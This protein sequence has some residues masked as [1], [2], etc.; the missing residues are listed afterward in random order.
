MAEVNVGNF[1]SSLFG[2]TPATNRR[3]TQA[4]TAATQTATAQRQQLIDARNAIADLMGTPAAADPAGFAQ[5]QQPGLERGAQAIRGQQAE[6]AARQAETTAQREQRLAAQQQAERGRQRMLNA[7]RLAND[8]VQAAANAGATPEEIGRVFDSSIRVA[9]GVDPSITD[10]QVAFLRE[11]VQQNPAALESII[12]AFDPPPATAARG[13]EALGAPQQVQVPGTDQVGLAVPVDMGGGRIQSVFMRDAQGEIL[14]A[15]R[16]ERGLAGEGEVTFRDE[17]GNLQALQ[18][19]GTAAE[20]ETEQTRVRTEQTREELREA[21][22][23]RVA[24]AQAAMRR[25][26]TEEQRFDLVDERIDQ[27]IDQASGL[28]AGL[29]S[30]TRF[31]PGSPAANLAATLDTIRANVG[32]DELQQLRDNSPTGGALGQVTERELAFLQAVLGSIEQSQSPRQLRENLEIMRQQLKQ[33]TE[34]VKSAFEEDFGVAPQ[35]GSSLFDLQVPEDGRST[36]GGSQPQNGG[37]FRR[38]PETGVWEMTNG[39]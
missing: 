30:V 19:P 33:S 13:P 16:F 24:E 38:N 10:E 1:L 14:P 12:T 20:A 15:A 36:N 39:N 29:G 21:N 5:A 26:E 6:T 18:I 35:T 3:A 31:V 23:E 8:R 32:F 2:S 28:T 22:R 27:A 7:T 25:A 4:N 11:Q 9:R 37:T 17:Q 34:R